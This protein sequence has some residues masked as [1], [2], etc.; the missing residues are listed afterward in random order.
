MLNFRHMTSREFKPGQ[1]AVKIVAVLVF[2]ITPTGCKHQPAEKKLSDGCAIASLLALKAIQGDP[3]VPEKGSGL[4]SRA[5][6]EKIDAA[7]VSAIS[8]EERGIAKALSVVYGGQLFQNARVNRL[9][10]LQKI[11]SYGDKSNSLKVEREE[12]AREVE[13][14]G[15]SLDGCFSDFDASLRSRSLAVPASCA[16]LTEEKQQLETEWQEAENK[17]EALNKEHQKKI[18]AEAYKQ[19]RSDDLRL[20][21]EN[22]KYLQYEGGFHGLN[23]AGQQRLH[24]VCQDVRSGKRH[25]LGDEFE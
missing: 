18:D 9:Q 11:A 24:E 16:A 22:D 10:I 23:K 2:V 3:Y 19:K 21:D 15:K 4:V 14:F 1:H 8:P 12:T 17:V 5:T 6:Q 25:D 7:D 13:T 20:C